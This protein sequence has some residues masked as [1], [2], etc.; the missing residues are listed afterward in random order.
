MFAPWLA[1]VVGLVMSAQLSAMAAQLSAQQ[2]ATSTVATDIRTLAATLERNA[3]CSG[4]GKFLNTTTGL[5]A[6]FPTIVLGRSSARTCSIAGQIKV[7]APCPP[8][9]PSLGAVRTH[10]GSIQKSSIGVRNLIAW[11]IV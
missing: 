6:G 1:P 7:G 9:L 3:V 4:Q 11:F 2:A 5:C 8:S 10:C